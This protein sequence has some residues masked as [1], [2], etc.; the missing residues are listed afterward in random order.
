VTRYI[1]DT[2]HV[3]LHQRGYRTVSR[4]WAQV[5]EDNVAVTV[6]TLEEQIRGRLAMIRHHSPT[7]QQRRQELNAYDD[8]WTTWGYFQL[9]TILPFDQ[10]SS[11]R[12][13]RL[14]QQGVRIGS[15]DLRIAAIALSL[16]AT[17]VTRNSRDF[18]R[19]PDLL[20][21]DWSGTE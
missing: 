10:T 8:F 15:Q 13:W 19:V 3:S 11:D 5:G 17:V 12:F 7:P 6:I 1:L 20:I 4:R 21:E 2:D 16:G 14:R 9:L 18:S